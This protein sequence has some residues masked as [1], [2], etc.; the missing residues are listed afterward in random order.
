MDNHE[1][2]LRLEECPEFLRNANIDFG[3]EIQPANDN[4]VEKGT[5]Y[6]SICMATL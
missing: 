6:D 3:D 5:H 2:E 4:T 1:L